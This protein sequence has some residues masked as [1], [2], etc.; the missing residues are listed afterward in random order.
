MLLPEG[1]LLQ[2]PF[3]LLQNYPA[4]AFAIA[5]RRLLAARREDAG[6]TA[7]SSAS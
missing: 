5:D 6:E 4:F 7:G 1:G 3:F 2:V